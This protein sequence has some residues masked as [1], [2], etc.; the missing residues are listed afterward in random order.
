MKLNRG[1]AAGAMAQATAAM[2]EAVT[3]QR[4]LR[5]LLLASSREDLREARSKEH[6]NGGD[7]G[8]AGSRQT[9]TNAAA[10]AAARSASSGAARRGAPG[11]NSSE[12]SISKSAGESQSVS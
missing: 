12:S 2:L 8:E 10:S 11:K 4:S 1:E 5:K 9:P 7:A 6:V 3:P